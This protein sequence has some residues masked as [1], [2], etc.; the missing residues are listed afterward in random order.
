MLLHAGSGGVG[1]YA[2]QL[3][4]HP[5]ATVTT[6][7][8][9]SNVEWVRDLGANVVIDYQTQ[10]FETVAHD[11]DIVL[12][13]Q[14]GDTPAKSLRVL[15]PGATAIGIAGRPTLQRG[16]AGTVTISDEEADAA[17]QELS[18]KGLTIGE[19]GARLMP[20]ANSMA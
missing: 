5:G 10:D 18:A 8:G 4:K 3:A 9:T 14:G 6:T 19:S 1:A 17:M 20:A 13:S 2:I 15:K 7:T 11:Y 16:I 12:D